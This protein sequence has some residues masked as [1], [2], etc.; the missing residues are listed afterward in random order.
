M[1]LNGK[2][3]RFLWVANE[4]GCLC[5]AK[6]WCMNVTSIP[7][8]ALKWFLISFLVPALVLADDKP[9]YLCTSKQYQ[10]S[11]GTSMQCPNIEKKLRDELW[12]YLRWSYRSYGRAEALAAYRTFKC[13]YVNL[14]N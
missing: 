6:R 9:T 2:K 8:I 10:F 3:N 4:H 14:G 1:R 11:F 5:A 12:R 7:P 13:G